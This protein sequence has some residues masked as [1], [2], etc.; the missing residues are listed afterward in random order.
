MRQKIANI[1]LV[2][3]IYGLLFI[4]KADSDILSGMNESLYST[5]QRISQMFNHPLD[6]KMK[7]VRDGVEGVVVAKGV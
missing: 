6:N 5:N 1:Y 4:T 3:T 2:R 7:G